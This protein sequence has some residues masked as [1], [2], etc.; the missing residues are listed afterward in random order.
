MNNFTRALTAILA[1]TAFVWGECAE[2]PDLNGLV[3][4]PATWTKVPND[5]FYECADL[6][7]VVIP[8][9]VTEIS[10]RAFYKSGLEVI[11]FEDN[12]QLKIIHSAA[13]Y[14]TSIVSIVIPQGVTHISDGAFTSSDLKVI[15]FEFPSQL[16]TIVG[17]AFAG[18]FIVSIVIPQGVTSIGSRTFAGTSIRSIVI[19]QGVTSFDEN[20]VFEATPCA[21]K[22]V[23][24]PGNTVVNCEVTVRTT[25]VPT[26]LAPTTAAPTTMAPTEVKDPCA[27]LN[28]RNCKTECVFSKR[29]RQCLPKSTSFEHDCAQYEGKTPCLE[30]K[31]CKFPHGKCVHRCDGKNAR[32]CR[33]HKFCNLD[34]VV[35]PCF[36]C[37]LVT[38]CGPRR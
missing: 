30:V 25:M 12:S 23:F 11:L 19:P 5:A 34:K 29:Q 20:N 8:R 6:K 21:D 24:K 17:V 36:G 31:V 18:T 37:H 22:T 1:N 9:G 14:D 13:F 33:K 10:H 3:T 2:K 4:I 7:E 35:N 16:E 26:T 38:A 15:E 28:K 32:R 27:N